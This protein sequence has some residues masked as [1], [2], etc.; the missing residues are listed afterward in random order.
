MD[1]T[2]HDQ[3][4]RQQ[5]MKSFQG[6]RLTDAQFETSW[7]IA[8]IVERGIRKSGSFREQLTDYAHAFSR[9]E[10]FDAVKGET[11]LRDIFKERYG[12]TMN[13]MREAMME[14]E[15]RLDDFASKEAL[16]MA[17][18]VPELVQLGE[19]MPFFKAYDQQAHTLSEAFQI[20]ETRAKQMMTETFAAAEGKELYEVGKE[21]EERV[22][23]PKV[24]AERRTRAQA[25]E[26]AQT[27]QQ[28]APQYARQR[29]YGPTR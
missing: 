8:G 13:Q 5:A 4:L 9:N 29:S 6:Q 24:E 21:V 1:A 7:A 25:R 15:A 26:Q 19:T 3:S 17:Q 20:T 27:S 16:R 14:R 11:I 22:H 10:K 23:R 12:Q 2:T 18:A 28:T